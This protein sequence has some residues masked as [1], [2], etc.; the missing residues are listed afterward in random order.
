MV[1]RL[2][3]I[4]PSKNF[5]FLKVF[6]RF[7]IPYGSQIEEILTKKAML[8]RSWAVLGVL[9]CKLGCLG[10]CWEQ[11]GAKEATRSAK[12]NHQKLKS[13]KI[14]L[15]NGRVALGWRVNELVWFLPA[16]IL[17][18]QVSKTQRL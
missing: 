17:R 8:S 6:R 3:T 10:G 14:H 9:G 2:N 1:V 13:L 7:G 4:N 5:R 12:M 18:L 11:D 15:Q 16:T